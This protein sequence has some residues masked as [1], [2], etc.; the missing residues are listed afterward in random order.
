V[1]YESPTDPEEKLDLHWPLTIG[2]WRAHP[3]ESDSFVPHVY[4]SQDRGHNGTRMES[5]RIAVSDIPA[6]IAALQK[7]LPVVEGLASLGNSDMG[8]C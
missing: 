6:V 8:P 1:T 7:K 3:I 2:A 5:V 4:L